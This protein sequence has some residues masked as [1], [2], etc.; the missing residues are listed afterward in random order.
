MD[1]M[2]QYLKT[3]ETRNGPARPI[4]KADKEITDHH[5]SL[6][7]GGDRFSE[8]LNPSLRESGIFVDWQLS[9]DRT[10]VRYGR[11]SLCEH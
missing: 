5:S 4:Y 11:H 10:K 1:I 7:E 6:G 3:V 2:G 8:T 9:T